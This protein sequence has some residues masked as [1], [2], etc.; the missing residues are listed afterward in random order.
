MDAK[1]LDGESSQA[2][3]RD[4]DRREVSWMNN[5]RYGLLIVLSLILT[6]GFAVGALYTA[7]YFDYNTKMR[8]DLETGEEVP[9]ESFRSSL[10]EDRPANQTYYICKNLSSG[11]EVLCNK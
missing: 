2:D 7:G 9:C 10:V 3:K 4:K 8:C 11:E 1:E 5:D 6:V